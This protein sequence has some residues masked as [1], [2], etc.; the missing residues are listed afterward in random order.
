MR[1]GIQ[2]HPQAG[3]AAAWSGDCIADHPRRRSL[4]ALQRALTQTTEVLARE[5]GRPG[6][7]A[8]QWS[9]TEWAVAR[10]VAAIH[11]VSPL[12]AGT[13]RWR[14][15]PSWS[16]FLELQ[17]VHT[18]QRFL[19]I[20]RLLQLIDARAREADIPAVALKGAALHALGIYAAGERPM[21][22]ID[23]LV[24]PEQSAAFARLLASVGYTETHRTWKHRVFRGADDADPA[25]LGEHADNSIKIELH[26]RIAE[27]LPRRAVDLT[28]IVFP[29]TPR[30]GLNGYR[31]KA[32]LLLHL[33]LHNAGALDRKSVV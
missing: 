2:R 24:R 10:A 26:C 1:T 25:A 11:G 3:A 16:R 21:A 5:L 13:L 28:R 22:D 31:S 7:Q 19:R 32:A 14:G 27:V 30:P 4:Q 6:A 29:E 33:L 9:E 20:Q 18:A 8:P 15:P 23:L 12:L 17:T